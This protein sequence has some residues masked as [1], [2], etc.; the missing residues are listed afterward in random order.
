METQKVISTSY[1]SKSLQNQSVN[2]VLN[3]FPSMGNHLVMDFNNVTSIDLNDYELLN[4]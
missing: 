2:S 3:P 4:Q 1:E